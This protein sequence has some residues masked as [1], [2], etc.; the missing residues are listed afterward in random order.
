MTRLWIVRAGAHGEQ[1]LDVITQG[2]LMLGF[3]EVGDLTG[4]KD[5][6]PIIREV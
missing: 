5:R 3:N 6:E 1:E 2:K 4:L